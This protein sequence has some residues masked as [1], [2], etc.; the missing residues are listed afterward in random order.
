MHQAKR[1]CLASGGSAA[2]AA[3]PWPGGSFSQSSSS[4]CAVRLDQTVGR[5]C[6]RDRSASCAAQPR[7][8]ADRAGSSG[9]GSDRTDRRR[10][11]RARDRTRPRNSAARCAR[12]ICSRCAFRSST[13]DWLK[14]HSLRIACSAPGEERTGA[15]SSSSS[16]RTDERF[17]AVIIGLASASPASA[18]P[19]IAAALDEALMQAEAAVVAD[20]DD[21][22]G[23]GAVLVAID[24]EALRWSRRFRARRS[25]SCAA[26]AASSSV[27]CVFVDLFELAET[28]LDALDFGGEFGR[29]FGRLR[30]H[31]R[32]LRHEA[33]FGIEH[34]LG[35]GPLR[36][37]FGGFGFEFLDREAGARGRDRRGSRR[38][39]R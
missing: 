13:S 27:Q 39:R 24:R 1:R 2:S 12:V 3:K 25:S 8:P 15:P 7:S 37:Q 29:N 6:R 5:R 11:H 36:T 14:P 22:A 28:L 21:A 17:V 23:A 19:R 10:A 31:A 33:V 35:P 9:S 20:R 34:G 26:S 4:A 38:R 16:R 30:P 18:S 32:I